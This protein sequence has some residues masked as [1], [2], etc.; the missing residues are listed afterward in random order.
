[1]I[2]VKAGD[3]PRRY[4]SPA[5]S[6]KNPV[7]GC[8]SAE[9]P[10]RHDQS[11]YEI[12]RIRRRQVPL[13]TQVTIAAKSC[14]RVRK[15]LLKRLAVLLMKWMVHLGVGASIILLAAGI[16]RRVRT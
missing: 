3:T 15:P 11:R 5:P 14:S 1:V 4:R 12:R 8:C 16:S 7:A 9:G 13:E 10:D 2:A 6:W